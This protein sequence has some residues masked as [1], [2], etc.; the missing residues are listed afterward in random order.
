MKSLLASSV[1]VQ[2]SSSTAV[3]P[4]LSSSK[5]SAA[6][7]VLVGLAMIS[8]MTSVPAAGQALSTVRSQS[9]MMPSSQT[10]GA[11]G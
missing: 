7:S 9:W 2:P 3:V 4:V 8:V 1:K 10:S 6:E 5:Y 11:P